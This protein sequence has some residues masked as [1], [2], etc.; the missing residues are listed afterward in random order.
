MKS[1]GIQTWEKISKLLLGCLES[2][3][4]SLC[5]R[6]DT[7][8][9]HHV[10]FTT[11]KYSVSTIIVPRKRTHSIYIFRTSRCYSPFTNSTLQ[12]TD[13]STFTGLD[14][15]AGGIKE[16]P[17]NCLQASVERISFC[18]ALSQRNKDMALH[19]TAAPY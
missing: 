10:T 8:S 11:C 6:D 16:C 14:S 12:T 2:R 5:L 7:P 3:D 19:R 13:C 17:V 4:K 1:V 15:S 18:V 9:S